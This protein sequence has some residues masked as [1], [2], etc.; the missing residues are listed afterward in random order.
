MEDIQTTP[1]FIEDFNAVMDK[2]NEAYTSAKTD[3]EREAVEKEFSTIIDN[4]EKVMEDKQE[5]SIKIAEK[6][7]QQEQKSVEDELIALEAKDEKERK[8]KQLAQE[9]ED[10]DEENIIDEEDRKYKSIKEVRGMSESDLVDYANTLSIKA[11]IKDK[12][13]DTLLKVIKMISNN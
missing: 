7:L 12:K 5:E 10:A 13:K 1:S 3:K 4:A 6:A 2:Y 11:S 8:E 9:K